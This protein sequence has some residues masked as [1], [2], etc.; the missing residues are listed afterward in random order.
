M[1]ATENDLPPRVPFKVGG[2]PTIKLFKAGEDKEIVDF[3]GNRSYEGFIEFLDQHAV[4]K[5]TITKAEEEK[6]TESHPPVETEQKHV[7]L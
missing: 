4:N 1:D 6:P 3:L 7:E 5:V 2:F